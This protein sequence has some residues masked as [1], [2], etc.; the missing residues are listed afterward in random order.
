MTKKLMSVMLG[1][2]LAMGSAV[3]V[4]GQDKAPAKQD[5]KDKAPAKQDSKDK[6]PAKQDSKD[7]APTKQDSRDKK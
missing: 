4:F 1:L 6:A 2:S 3:V 7:K 5:S